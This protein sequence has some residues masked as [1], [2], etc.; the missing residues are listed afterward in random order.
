VA[1]K[2]EKKILVLS[3]KE[4]TVGIIP[5]ERDV[6]FRFD[7]AESSLALMPEFDVSI[8]LSP[9][10]ARGLAATLIRKAAEA[11]GLTSQ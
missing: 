9:T 8:R 7:L 4:V 5:S 11:E 1:S 3:A 6:V 2:I 10:E